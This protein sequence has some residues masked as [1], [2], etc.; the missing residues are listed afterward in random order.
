MSIDEEFATKCLEAVYACH[1]GSE[2]PMYYK[3]TEDIVGDMLMGKY[4]EGG[5]LRGMVPR[6]LELID[7]Y[8]QLADEFYEKYHFC[9]CKDLQYY[10]IYRGTNNS[11]PEFVPGHKRIALIPFSNSLEKEN[12]FNWVNEDNGCCVWR[13]KV[14]VDTKFLCL[15]NDNEGK[16]TVLPAGATIIDEVSTITDPET[17]NTYIMYDCT[18]TAT[19]PPPDL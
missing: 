7:N 5:V 17:G 4:V 2:D 14:P 1:V 13:I 16:E 12:V 9:A 15:D 19:V 3:V 6:V 10:V 11:S 18:F 8:Y